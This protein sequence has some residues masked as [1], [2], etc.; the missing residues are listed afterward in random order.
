MITEQR[1][2]RR[3]A[4]SELPKEVPDYKGSS[5][6]K[7]IL[8]E[9]WLT[10]WIKEGLNSRKIMPDNLLP[11]KSKLAYYLGVS[12][13]TV[14]SAL[15]YMEDKGIVESKQRIGTYIK[16]PGKNATVPEKLTGKRDLNIKQ[17]KNFI[18]DNNIEIGDRLP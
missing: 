1:E 5:C 10:K 6:S 11:I 14:Q 12:V 7:D 13:G 16:A 2:K 3:I 8:T 4:I 15:R 17:L 9:K 18:I